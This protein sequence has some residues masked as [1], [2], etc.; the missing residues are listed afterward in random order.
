MVMLA[1]LGA[2]AKRR[3]RRLKPANW[4]NEASMMPVWHTTIVVPGSAAY[5][6]NADRALRSNSFQVSPSANALLDPNR[7]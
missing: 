5:L 7:S 6:H 4:M 1:F 3:A 2:M